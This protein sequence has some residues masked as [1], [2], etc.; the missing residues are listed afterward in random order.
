ML[1]YLSLEIRSQRTLLWARLSCRGSDHHVPS[2]SLSYSATKQTPGQ[3]FRPSRL[4]FVCRITHKQGEGLLV[5]RHLLFGEGISL[6]D[7]M[8]SEVRRNSVA[9]QCG[10]LIFD[11]ATHKLR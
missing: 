6:Q 5:L 3:H 1:E 11:N 7:A 10:G 8:V 4:R 9:P 2:P